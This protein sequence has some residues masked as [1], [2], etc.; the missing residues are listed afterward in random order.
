MVTIIVILVCGFVILILVAKASLHMFAL[1]QRG[2]ND[3]DFAT[4]AFRNLVREMKHDIIIHDDGERGSF[5]DEKA[6]VDL[7]QSRLQEG[8]RVRCLLNNRISDLRLVELTKYDNFELQY[9]PD[10]FPQEP[11]VHYKIVDGGAKA[12][13]SMHRGQDREYELFNCLRYPGMLRNAMFAKQVREF[14][15]LMEAIALE[16]DISDKQM[17]LS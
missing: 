12:Y 14:D 1:V 4:D 9:M 2:V 10:W 7:I 13:L 3:D 8:C 16:K 17:V 6:T 15:E 5:Y 11:D